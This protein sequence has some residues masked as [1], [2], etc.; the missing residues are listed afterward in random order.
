[1]ASEHLRNPWLIAAWPGMG[2]VAIGAAAY[3]VEKLGAQRLGELPP[4]DYFDLKRIEVKGG[5]AQPPRF[6]RSTFYGWRDP[7]GVRD[8][9][10]F[11]G[12]AQPSERGFEF[13]TR[14]LD[15]AMPYGVERVFTFAAMATPI[16][17]SADPRVFAVA[18]QPALLNEVRLDAAGHERA[19]VLAEG[20]ITGL[21]GV[22]LAA[23]MQRGLGG[24]CLLGELPFFAIG[25]P[26]PKASLAVLRVFQAASGIPIDL[27]EIET[28][29]QAVER[30]LIQLLERMQAAARQ[31]RAAAASED[32]EEGGFSVPSFA[33][34]S[35]EEDEEEESRPR[36]DERARQRI[37]RLFEQAREDRTKALDLKAELDR[38]GVFKEYED[39]FLDLFKQAE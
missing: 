33:V 20:E 12:E 19:H 34:E 27:S 9:V 5:I 15:H 21:N 17:P 2:N 24:V 38:L 10:I 16:H 26:N 14:L 22:L 31:A 36:L 1:M 23:A 18:T 39:R 29:A 4:G 13:A 6:P 30:G 32:E 25:V 8:L 11:V 28:Q 37:E 7:A 35:E 3:L